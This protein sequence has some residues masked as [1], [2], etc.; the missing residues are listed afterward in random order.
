MHGVLVG[1][2]SGETVTNQNFDSP[3]SYRRCWRLINQPNGF[4]KVLCTVMAVVKVVKTVYKACYQSRN[5][6]VLVK[7]GVKDV[8]NTAK[9]V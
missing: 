8:F 4:C 6:S 1:E 2:T 7:L 3:Q 9:N 5:I